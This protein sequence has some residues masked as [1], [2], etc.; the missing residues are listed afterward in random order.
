MRNFTVTDEV[1]DYAAEYKGSEAPN[2]A[3]EAGV[4]AV[5]TVPVVLDDRVVAAFMVGTTDAHR[6]FDVVDEQGNPVPD[7][8]KGILVIRKPWGELD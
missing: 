5:V 2:A 4:H 8:Q 3:L 6:R 1:R 7:G